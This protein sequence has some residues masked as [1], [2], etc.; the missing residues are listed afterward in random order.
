MDSMTDSQLIDE[1]KKRFEEK[2][3]ALFDLRV[4]TKKLETL[5]K[6]LQESEAL[7]SNFLS[8][9]KNEINNPLTSILGLTQ[10]LKT[11]V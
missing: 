5:N 8:N 3:K 9:I 11:S 4:M 2:D 1:L 10:Q 7:K 6:R